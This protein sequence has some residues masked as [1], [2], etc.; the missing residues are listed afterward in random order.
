MD[1]ITDNNI[2]IGG[3][4]GFSKTL[5]PTIEEAIENNMNSL[6]FF[7]GNPKAFK[8]QRLYKDDFFKC[9]KYCS[10]NNINLYSHYPYT[11]SLVGSV[12]SLAWNGDIEQDTKT[13]NILKELELEINT[14]GKCCGK[15]NMCGC[16]IHPGS[17]KNR[18]DGLTTIG[19]SINKIKFENHSKLLLENCAGQGTTLPKNLKEFVKIYDAIESSKKDNIGICLDTA[20]IFGSGIYD[21]RKRDEVDKLFHDFDS[22]IGLDK[23]NLLHLND[24][25]VKFGSKKDRHECLGKGFIWENDDTALKYLLKKC[26]ENKIPIVLETPD[27]LNDLEVVRKFE[28]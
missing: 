25:A 2:M 19:K 7:M 5:Y 24:S 14:L 15:N 26:A 28:F 27:I 6:Q 17:F 8:R 4:I 10:E 22:L 16:V 11:S 1:F 12:K 21:L 23:F 13:E 18:D 9:T 20:H 3:H